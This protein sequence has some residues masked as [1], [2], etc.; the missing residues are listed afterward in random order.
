MI[1]IEDNDL[2]ITVAYKIVSGTKPYNPTPFTKAF[3]SA[4]TGCDNA[5]EKIDMFD[6]SEIREIA[7]HLLVFCRANEA[8]GEA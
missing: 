3:V 1:Q 4:V 8:E 7:E 5:G 2:P 6:V